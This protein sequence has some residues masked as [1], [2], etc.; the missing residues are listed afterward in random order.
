LSYYHLLDKEGVEET[1][2]GEDRMK[3]GLDLKLCGV[4]VCSCFAPFSQVP[5]RDS[6]RDKRRDRWTES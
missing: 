4:N 5:A 6:H 1:P 3:G 2:E